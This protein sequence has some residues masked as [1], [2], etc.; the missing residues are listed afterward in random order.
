MYVDMHLLSSSCTNTFVCRAAYIDQAWAALV[1]EL[2]KHAR[3]YVHMHL[4]FSFCKNTFVCRAYIHEAW[5][6]LVP[7]FLGGIGDN[8]LDVRET[9]LVV[10]CLHMYIQR[11]A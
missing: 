5:A 10:V 6:A 4:L 3:M 2:L 1:P 7:E 11:T 8:E 9:M